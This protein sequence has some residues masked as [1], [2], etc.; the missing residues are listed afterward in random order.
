[1]IV[2]IMMIA[3]PCAAMTALF[4]V[5][6]LLGG[7]LKNFGIHPRDV[8]SLYTIFTAPWLH[9]DFWHLANNM[10]GFAVFGLLTVLNGPRYFAV[11]SAIIIGISG[12]LLWL[13]GRDAN[14]IGAS[15][16]IFGLWSL[17]IALAWFERSLRHILIG[18]AVIFFYGTMLFGMLPSDQRIS[19]EGHIFGALAG[20]VAAWV[21]SRKKALPR[22][23]TAPKDNAPRFWP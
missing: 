14:H 23:A 4:I 19:F 9:A 11:A 2:R 6:F 3:L 8:G 18:M 20:I 5:D 21:L 22:M 13:F 16:W 7:A 15:G 12:L 17:T 10:A 1:M